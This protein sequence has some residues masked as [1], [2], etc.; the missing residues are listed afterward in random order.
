MGQAFGKLKGLD[1][2]PVMGDARER[3]GAQGRINR[4]LNGELGS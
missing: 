2:E 3:V 1:G 4:I